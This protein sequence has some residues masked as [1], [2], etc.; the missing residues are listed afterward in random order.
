MTNK[1]TVCVTSL[2]VQGQL[3]KIKKQLFPSGPELL[4]MDSS[5]IFLLID[6]LCLPR[7]GF[8]GGTKASFSGPPV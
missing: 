2:N 3:I 4:N 7:D 8:C 1:G 6:A 5:N